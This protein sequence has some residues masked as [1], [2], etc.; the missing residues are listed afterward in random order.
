MSI[1]WI[2]ICS[3]GTKERYQDNEFHRVD[4]PAVED[5]YGAKYWYQYGKLHRVDG[6]AIETVSGIKCWYQDGKRHR[7]DGPAIEYTDGTKEWYYKGIMI[8]CTS[9]QD[10]MRLINLKAFW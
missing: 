4:G 10:F 1:R 9:Q 7:V 5:A 3:N 2:R 6:P 8:D